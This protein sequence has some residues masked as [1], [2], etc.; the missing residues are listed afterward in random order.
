MKEKNNLTAR[1]NTRI[2]TSRTGFI[3]TDIYIRILDAFGR[4]K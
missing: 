1:G 2:S 4:T 3:E